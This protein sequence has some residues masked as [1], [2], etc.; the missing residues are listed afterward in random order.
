M[1]DAFLSLVRALL[2]RQVRFVVIGVW[3]ANYYAP[4]AA[5]FFETYDRDLFLPLDA[6]NLL[7]AWE[8]AQTAGLSLWAGNEPLDEPRDLELAQAVTARRALIH[9]TDGGGLD[10][11]VTLVM[12]GFDFEAVWRERR[13]FVSEGVPVPVARLMHIVKSKETADRDKDR[14]FLATH[15][16]ALRQLLGGE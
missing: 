7:S 5:A 4:S 2:D 9:A 14:L 15:A 12:A 8:A 16:E 11:D 3:G 1:P 10:V 13:T 6:P